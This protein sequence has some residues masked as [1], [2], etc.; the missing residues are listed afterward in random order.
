MR[1][2]RGR[3]VKICVINDAVQRENPLL[4]FKW[5]ELLGNGDGS[6][7]TAGVAEAL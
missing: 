4:S 3:S 6:K 7:S 1:G 2:E 5:G